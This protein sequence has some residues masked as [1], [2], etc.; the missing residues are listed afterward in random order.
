MFSDPGFH[1]IGFGD[2]YMN[3]VEEK[4]VVRTEVAKGV[5][6]NYGFYLKFGYEF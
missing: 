3:K 4:M 2:I 5:G 6:E 1:A